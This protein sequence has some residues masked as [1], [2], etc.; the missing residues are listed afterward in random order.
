MRLFRTEWLLVPSFTLVLSSAYLGL[1]PLSLWLGVILLLM[2]MIS[3]LRFVAF[4]KLWTQAP[5]KK[6]LK[7][8]SL[9]VSLVYAVLLYVAFVLLYQILLTLVIA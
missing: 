8:M 6:R 7:L 5:L 2:M 1:V 3:T 9:S 4:T